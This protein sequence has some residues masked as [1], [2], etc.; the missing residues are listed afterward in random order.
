MWNKVWVVISNY[1]VVRIS[2]K[3]FLVLKIKNNVSIWNVFNESV[4]KRITYKC[5]SKKQQVIF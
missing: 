1:Y 2:W 5:F 4:F 3:W